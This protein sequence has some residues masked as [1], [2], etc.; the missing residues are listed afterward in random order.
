MKVN[1]NHKPLKNVDVEMIG[2]CGIQI[3]LNSWV[4][5]EVFGPIV[6]TCESVILVK[7]KC[8]FVRKLNVKNEIMKSK[9]RLME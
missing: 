3:E 8:V 6:Q 4:K 1:L 9:V 5:Y 7:Y 2:Q